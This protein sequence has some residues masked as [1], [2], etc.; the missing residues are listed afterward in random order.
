MGIRA[1]YVKYIIGNL[2]PI[3][4]LTPQGTWGSVYGMHSVLF[5]AHIPERP[6]QGDWDEFLRCATK[7]AKPN[8]GVLRLSENVWLID[9]SSSFSPLAWLVADAERL[10]VS[11]GILP[12]EHEPR[13]LPAGFD[14]RTI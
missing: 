11:Y 7:R 2:F 10:K 1:C 8:T 13:W 3:I 9:V 14:P 6:G 12:F 4:S 5:V